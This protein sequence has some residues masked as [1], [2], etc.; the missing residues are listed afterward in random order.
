MRL[1]GDSCHNIERVMRLPG[2]KNHKTGQIAR[3]IDDDPER[4]YRREDFTK[5]E[6]SAPAPTA[7][8]VEIGGAVRV[9]DLVELDD[10][11]VPDRVK[12]IIAQGR[13]P[14]KPKQKDNSR[15]AWLMDAVCQLVRCGVPLALI[16]GIITDRGWKISDSIFHEKDGTLKS[17]PENYARRQIEKA[18]ALVAQDNRTA[19]GN[20]N[21]K[22]SDDVAPAGSDDFQLNK[23]G[24]PYPNQHNIRV[25]LRKLDVRLSYDRFADRMLIEGLVWGRSMCCKTPT[26]PGS[27][28][29]TDDRFRLSAWLRIFYWTVIDERSATEQLS[30]RSELPGKSYLGWNAAN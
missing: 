5:S 21:L 27:G 9:R 10:W 28:L 11:N 8:D 15:S 22:V 17:N 16:L 1:G 3:V 18:A 20:D 25:A 30:S 6:I 19:A 4:V 24:V 7:P 26:L 12:V 13:D 14:D 23:D 2:T 29:E